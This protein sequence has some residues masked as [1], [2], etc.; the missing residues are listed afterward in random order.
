M[1][2]K[3]IPVSFSH[4]E[5][6]ILEGYLKLCA[7]TGVESVTLDDIAKSVHLAFAT[8]HYHFGGKKRQLLPLFAATH[9]ARIAGRFTA[10]Y[11]ERAAREPNYVP[12]EAYVRATFEWVRKYKVHASFWLHH[13]YLASI[14]SK[15]REIN[16]NAITAARKRLESLLFETAGRIA[17]PARPDTS[18]L[19]AQIHSLIMGSVIIALTDPSSEAVDREEKLCLAAIARWS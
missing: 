6:Q 14:R 1:P 17:A 5:I 3:N 8:I 12:M 4:T 10:E 13:I 16:S 9:I 19:A 15:I 18:E 11:L 7:K 2:Q